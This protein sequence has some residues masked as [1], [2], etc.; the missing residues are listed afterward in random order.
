MANK[1]QKLHTHTQRER[2]KESEQQRTLIDHCCLLNI[3]TLQLHIKRK[4]EHKKRV[5][6]KGV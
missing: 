6:C 1:Q 4:R 5:Q 2:D 3:N